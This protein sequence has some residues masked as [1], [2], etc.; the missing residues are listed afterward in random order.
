MTITTTFDFPVYPTLPA[1]DLQ[2]AR[3]WYR[4]KLGGDARGGVPEGLMYRTGGGR[5]ELHPSEFSG[6]NQATAATIIVDDVD[7][8]VAHLASRGV[9]SSGMTSRT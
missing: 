8:V 9:V 3:E 6:T 1:A 7:R 5:W 2:R 4:E